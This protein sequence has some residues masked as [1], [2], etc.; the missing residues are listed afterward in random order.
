MKKAQTRI[1]VFLI[2]SF[3]LYGAVWFYARDKQA[4]WTNVPPVP[5]A[6]A[7]QA[8]MLGDA[9]MAY[10]AAGVV[11]QNLG[12]TGG[13]STALRDY[14]Y[15]RLGRWFSRMDE[16]DHRSDFMPFL[17]AYYYGATPA[18]EDLPPVVNY[19]AFV[20]EDPQGEKWR[21]LAQAIFLAR[22]RMGDLNEA[23]R[24][25]HRLAAMWHEGMPGWAE[26][27][28]AFVMMAKGDK[29]AAYELMMRLLTSEV[30]KL[31]PAEIYFMKDY[32]CTRIL[33]PEEA[34]P[35]PLCTD[36]MGGQ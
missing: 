33:S 14:D 13:R 25:S 12:D 34:A 1:V 19:L 5:S 7:G 20:G 24:L 6:Q 29:E 22:Y 36:D 10:R 15:Q 11:L 21:W 28:P 16:W 17:A 32:I 35:H 31:H 8:L 18:T 26:Q 30:D 9:Q 4:V 23:L 3:L 2:W 27:M